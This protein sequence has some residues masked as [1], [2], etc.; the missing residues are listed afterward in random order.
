[1]NDDDPVSTTDEPT[2]HVV[3]KGKRRR[4]TADYKR[5]IL[6]EADACGKQ[7]ETGALLRREGLYWSHLTSWRAARAAGN[8][9]GPTKKRGPKPRP[10]DDI[11]RRIAELERENAKLRARAERAEI[12]VDC[13]KKIAAL[14]GRPPAQRCE[15]R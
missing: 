6:A 2:P 4:F 12:L 13:Q 15:P 8:L 7:G 14:L 10:L 11:E 1:M 3:P 5:R 9:A